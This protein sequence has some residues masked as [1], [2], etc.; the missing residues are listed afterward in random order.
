MKNILRTSLVILFIPVC[1][2][3]AFA[4]DTPILKPGDPAPKFVLP[5]LGGDRV[6]LSDMCGE[7]LRQPWKNTIKYPVVIS[8]F[9]STCEPCKIEIPLLQEIAK[10]YPDSVK[11]F[12]I[13]VGEPE[14]KVK[15]FVEEQGYTLPVLVDQFM[16]VSKNYGDARKVP[17]L[18]LIDKE[19][20]IRL[21]CEGYSEENMEELKGLL[22]TVTE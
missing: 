6:F 10:D 16:M 3:S 19:G 21:F 20:V 13:A 17:K 1:I 7:K 8:F 9:S 4:S 2:L 11:F 14:E 15:A 22:K 5:E 12:L 18:A